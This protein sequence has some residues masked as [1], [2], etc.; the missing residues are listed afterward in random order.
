VD[1]EDVAQ[2]QPTGGPTNR[3]SGPQTN[4]KEGVEGQVKR[5][6]LIWL[7]VVAA[8]ALPA[9]AVTA[10]SASAAEPE[11]GHCV[12][13]KSKGHYED[14]N[15][16]KEAFTENKKHVKKYKGKF[17]WIPGSA[18]ACFAQKHGK[19]KDAGCTEED[20]KKGAPKGKYEKTGGPKFAGEGGAGVLTS[21]LDGCEQEGIHK[22]LPRKDC[23]AEGYAEFGAAQV[24]C[25][26]EH[27]SGEAAGSDEV[28]NISVRFVSCTFFGVPATTHGLPTGEIQVNPLKGR[29]GYIN[30]AKHEVGVLLEPATGGLFAEFEVLEGKL[31]DRVGVGNAL[32]GSFYENAGTPGEPNGHEGV[33]SP[34]IP[35]DQMTHT[36]TQNYR[37]EDRKVACPENCRTGE[38]ELQEWVNVPSSFEGGQLEALESHTE[39]TVGEN[40]GAQNEWGAAAQEVTNV[41]TLE[42]EAEIKG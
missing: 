15:C 33:I 9:I 22:S 14:G 40:A 28:K 30:K 34:I 17:E 31:V 32:E 25:Q 6:K 13:V 36:F 21:T 3:R 29:L 35:V 23:E 26:S 16:S 39:Q 18:A 19:Y 38:P 37:G 8:F 24:E 10:S 1:V 42:G 41:N 5:V 27:A 2:E 4:A 20:L 11:W 12:A 7:A